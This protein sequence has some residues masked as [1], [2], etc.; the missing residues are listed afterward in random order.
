MARS[1]D[2]CDPERFLNGPRRAID[3]EQVRACGP[4]RFALPLLPMS[5]GVDAEPESCSEGLLCQAELR[6]NRFD[7]DMLGYVDAIVLLRR[8]AL[9]VRDRLFETLADAVRCPA[10]DRRLPYVST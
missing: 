10:H 1:A 5:Q 2:S 3:D 4:F 6:P 7:V 9:R 8:T